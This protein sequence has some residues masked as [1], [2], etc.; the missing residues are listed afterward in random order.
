MF[1]HP[2]DFHRNRFFVLEIWSIIK[3]HCSEVT[4]LNCDNNNISKLDLFRTLHSKAPKLINFSFAGVRNVSLFAVLLL[5][6]SVL[7][8]CC[9]AQNNIATLAELDNLKEFQSQV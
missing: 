8:C 7:T 5:C 1:C 4:T 2:P 3:E 9:C 6:V